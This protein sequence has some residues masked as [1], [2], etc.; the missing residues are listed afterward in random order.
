MDTESARQLLVPYIDGQLDPDTVGEID[1]CLE[2]DPTLRLE[3][4]QLRELSTLLS[5]GE[6]LD[7]NAAMQARFN[8]FIE[9]E[10]TGDLQVARPGWLDWFT[11]FSPI[12]RTSAAVA[13]VCAAVVG[14]WLLGN[15]HDGEERFAQANGV[16]IP[17]SR[18]SYPLA[19]GRLQWITDFETTPQL[20]PDLLETLMGIVA[21]DPNGAVRLAA[22]NALARFI[23]VPV[24]RRQLIE[25][26]PEETDP[27]MQIALIEILSKTGTP[28]ARA[29]IEKLLVRR[30]VRDSVKGQAQ[31]G[32]TYY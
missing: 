24:V 32:L 30:D 5:G 17:E 21:D 18:P 10:T 12:V 31:L 4:S 16:D 28:E 20:E 6:T 13:V 14:I 27:M 11:A 22:L 26:L 25:M 2:N 3:L 29:S 19:S 23:D 1:Q 9:Q 8:R 7:V 15:R